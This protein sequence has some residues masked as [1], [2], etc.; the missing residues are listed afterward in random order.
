MPAYRPTTLPAASL[1]LAGLLV[2]ALTGCGGSSS[3]H[4]DPVAALKTAEQ[5]LENTSGVTMSL[6]TDNLPSG[7]QGV[8]GAD[9]TVTSSPAAFDGTL[10]AVISFGSVSVPIR[11]VDGKVYAQ[12]PLTSGWTTVNP[13]DYGAPDPAQ[14]LSSDQGI[15]AVLAATKNPRQDGQVRGGPDNKEVLTRYTGTV[16]SSAA[17]HLI[18]GANGDFKATYDITSGGELRD[19]ELTGAFYRGKPDV[20]YTLELDNYGTQKDITAP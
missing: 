13:S 15:P 6:A 7:V 9:G 17:A 8:K 16:P 1:L 12:I 19:A 11:S 20:T 4:E 5:K 2:G 10:N 14:L 3:S 18:P